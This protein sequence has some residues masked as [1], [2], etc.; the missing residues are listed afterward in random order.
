MR[1]NNDES[2]A[3]ATERLFN[4]ILIYRAAPIIIIRYFIINIMRRRFAASRSDGKITTRITK[5]KK[6]HPLPAIIEAIQVGGLGG[7][8]GG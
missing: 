8:V 3:A 4:K 7:G 2:R 1:T 6:R 5:K